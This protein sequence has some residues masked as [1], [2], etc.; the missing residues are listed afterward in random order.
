[1]CV[2]YYWL[3]AIGI[4]SA[5]RQK[6]DV[7]FFRTVVNKSGKQRGEQNLIKGRRRNI[8]RSEDILQKL[9]ALAQRRALGSVQQLIATPLQP[10]LLRCSLAFYLTAFLAIITSSLMT[11]N[12]VSSE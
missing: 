4:L 1:M 12:Q 2:Y 7:F 9:A 11:L 3:S 10:L 8:F 5:F 6:N